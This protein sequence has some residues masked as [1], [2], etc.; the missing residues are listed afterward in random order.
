[1][2]YVHRFLVLCFVVIASTILD[3]MIYS[4]IFEG[5]FTGAE[6]IICLPYHS[7]IASEVILKDMDD[8][9]L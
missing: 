9:G 7:P 5:N 8:M 4:S 1:M 3:H 2:K 6:A